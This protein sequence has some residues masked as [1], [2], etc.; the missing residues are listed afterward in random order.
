MQIAW[1]CVNMWGHDLLENHMLLMLLLCW[2][3][4]WNMLVVMSSIPDIQTYKKQTCSVNKYKYCSPL[5]MQVG[6]E[7]MWKT[8]FFENCLVGAPQRKPLSWARWSVERTL[9]P[10]SS[11]FVSDD[12][13]LHLGS[14][15]TP[16]VALQMPVPASFWPFEIFNITCRK[17]QCMLGY[18][19]EVWVTLF[20]P[21]NNVQLSTHRRLISTN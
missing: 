11:G 17:V 21:V 8:K 3:N 4:R 13:K 19:K 1:S 14:P 9:A 10:N 2:H 16:S 7:V 6:G 5:L 15:W 12:K 18:T 20:S